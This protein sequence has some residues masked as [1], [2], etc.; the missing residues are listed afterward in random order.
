MKLL[1]Q[2]LKALRSFHVVCVSI[3]PASGGLITVSGSVRV[4]KG[5]VKVY[6]STGAVVALVSLE[7]ITAVSIH[8][9]VFDESL[10]LLINVK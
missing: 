7:G 9:S 10:S 2:I 5:R 1:S 4:N 3:S 6:D 8:Q